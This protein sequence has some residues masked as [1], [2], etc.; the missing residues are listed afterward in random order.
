M[1]HVE[2]IK[3]VTERARDHLARGPCRLAILYIYER[4]CVF[5]RACARVCM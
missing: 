2:G 3:M 4:V 5:V 1:V